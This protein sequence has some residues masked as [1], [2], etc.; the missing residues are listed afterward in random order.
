M[1]GVAYWVSIFPTDVMKSR[2]QVTTQAV[3]ATQIRY[4]P[5]MMK[6]VKEEG[7]LSLLLLLSRT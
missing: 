7:N 1:G 4:F 3:E 5:L 6:I 2:I